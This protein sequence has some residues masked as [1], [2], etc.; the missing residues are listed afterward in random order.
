MPFYTPEFLLFFAAV[1]A[2]A[3]V[4]RDNEQRKRVLLIASCAFC[5]WASLLSL[6]VLFVAAV[7]TYRAGQAMSVESD[8]RRKRA[9]LILAIAVNL[10]LLG[11]FK[12]ADFAR[13]NVATALAALGFVVELRPLGWLLPLGISFYTLQAIGYAIEVHR[14]PQRAAPSFADFLLYL[15]FF[16]R[17]SSGPILRASAFLPQ[18]AKPGAP[19]VDPEVIVLFLGGLAKKVLVADN[20]APFVDA[21]YADV[22][23][24]PG[25]V[26]WLATLAFA[27]Q[28]YCDF[29]GYTDMAIA[30]GRVLGYRLPEN[31]HFPFLARNP[32]DLWRRWHVSFSSWLRD[33]VYG[34][35]PGSAESFIA[36]SRNILLTML[37]AGLWHGATWG[38]VLWG[39]ANGV[40]LV[41]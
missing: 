40:L 17:F 37:L 30:L 3:T 13:E 22:N 19:R 20:L 8:P 2:L 34:S 21:V 33:Y 18:L 29:S 27:V 41:V 6:I 36:R 35:L 9:S 15:A 11:F 12:Y 5:A 7:V 28:I 4:V 31:F 10:L 26:I 16:P 23:A 14:R 24:W 38:Y 25:A 1:A 32:S 39:L